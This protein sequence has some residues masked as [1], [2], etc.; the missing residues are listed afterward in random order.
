MANVT[1][2][3]N[4]QLLKASREY[5]RRHGTSLNALIRE[6]LERT[7]NHPRGAWPDDFLACVQKARGNSRGWKWNREELYDV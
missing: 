7:V 1:I 6:L 3:L 5:A 4:E 2:S